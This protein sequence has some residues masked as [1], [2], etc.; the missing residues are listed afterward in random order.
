MR[1]KAV[2]AGKMPTGNGFVPRPGFAATKIGLQ[3]AQ[4][5]RTVEAVTGLRVETPA[6]RAGVSCFALP[7][8]ALLAHLEK[9]HRHVSIGVHGDVQKY[10]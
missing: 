9:I 5:T 8:A 7:V 6:A 2:I 4:P 3:E 1:A 10:V